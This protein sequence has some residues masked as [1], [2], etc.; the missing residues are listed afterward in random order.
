MTGVRYPEEATGKID[1][2]NKIN[3]EINIIMFSLKMETL[4]SNG[5]SNQVKLE[6][7]I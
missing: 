7:S 2:Y 1:L 4:L 3:G 6:F 5:S